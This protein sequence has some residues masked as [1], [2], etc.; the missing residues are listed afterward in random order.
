M[1][2]NIGDWLCRPG[3]YGVAQVIDTE[4]E[5]YKEVEVY[6]LKTLVSPRF[7]IHAW[8]LEEEIKAEIYT[9]PVQ[10]ICI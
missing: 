5:F 10:K 1:S 2:F 9:P 8:Y 4:I 7:R 3:G 6:Y